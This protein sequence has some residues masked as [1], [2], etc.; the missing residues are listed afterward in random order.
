MGFSVILKCIFV[1]YFAAPSRW[2]VGFGT[3]YKRRH[4]P[5][6]GEMVIVSDLT[7]PPLSLYLLLEI[8][9]SQTTSILLEM[10][11]SK[12]VVKGT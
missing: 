11:E 8:G 12:A 1:R 9:V 7:S 6:T 4:S 10:V 2:D 5:T 3:T